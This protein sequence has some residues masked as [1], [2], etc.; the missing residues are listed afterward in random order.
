MNVDVPDKIFCQ[1]LLLS[2]PLLPVEDGG[3]QS[4]YN[5]LYL[6]VRSYK[7]PKNIESTNLAALPQFEY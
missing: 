2:F 1:N 3:V 5:A 6:K 4:G 7:I